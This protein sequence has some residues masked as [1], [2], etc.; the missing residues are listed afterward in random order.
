MNQAGR[1]S[2][3]RGDGFARS[4]VSSAARGGMLIAFAIVIGLVLLQVIDNA[5]SNGSTDNGVSAT[6]TSPETSPPATEPTDTTQ[7][8][9]DTRPPNEIRVLV[10]NGAD[11]DA[12]LAG[13]MTEALRA[14]GYQTVPPN[15]TEPRTGTVVT[16][17]EAFTADAPALAAAVGETAVVEDFADPPPENAESLEQYDCLVVLGS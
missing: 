11:P 13:T 15:D 14:A 2:G 9:A 5:S 3:S 16:C 4:A 12:P 7:P 1:S 10:L 6:T 8:T 17:Q